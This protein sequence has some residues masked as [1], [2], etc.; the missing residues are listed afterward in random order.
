[1]RA[2]LSRCSLSG[3]VP[4]SIRPLPDDH[5]SITHGQ[6]KIFHALITLD[7]GVELDHP[8]RLLI[9]ISSAPDH[10]TSS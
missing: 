5:E 10:S 9:V 3:I 7:T 8:A 2:T 1:L 4:G 6:K